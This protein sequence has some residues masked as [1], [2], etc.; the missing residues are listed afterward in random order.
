VD[1]RKAELRVVHA[2]DE[3]V[4]LENVSSMATRHGAIAAVNAGFFKTTGTYRGDPSGVLVLNG[5]LLSEPLNYRASVG[6]LERG[7]KTEISFPR[8]NF[9]GRL[10]SRGRAPLAVNGIN[11]ERGANE[12]VVYTPEFHR[13]TLTALDGVEL[14]VRRSRIVKRKDGRGSSKIPEDGYVVSAS[15]RMRELAL[16]GL[17]VGSRVNLSFSLIEAAGDSSARPLRGYVVGGG[18]GLIAKGST[19]IDPQREGIEPR[20]VSDRHPRTAVAKL[21]DGRV[22]FATVDGRQ[23]GVSAGMSLPELASLLLECGAV[24]AV[25]LDGGG[26]TTMVIRGRLVNKPSDPSGER[27]VSDAILVL[28]RGL[29]KR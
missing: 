16:K 29:K 12:L 23:P 11:R 7:G 3:V 9:S 14:I 22:L 2:L 10:R 8:L 26:S 19:A 25:N 21:K 1:T 4:G 27:P 18:P 28:A 6:L 5:K 24:D 17:P 20:F 15:G 13:T